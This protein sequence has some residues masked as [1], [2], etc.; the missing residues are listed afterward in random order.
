MT[1]ANACSVLAAP[2]AGVDLGRVQGQEQVRRARMAAHRVRRPGEQ[3]ARQQRKAAYLV[4]F[5]VGSGANLS[6]A[7]PSMISASR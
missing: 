6:L 2:R 5:G 7:H 3:V 1:E 4:M